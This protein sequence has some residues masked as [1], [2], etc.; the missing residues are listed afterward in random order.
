L[1]FLLSC[2]ANAPSPL[3]SQW[4][5]K[6]IKKG[7]VTRIENSR[8]SAITYSDRAKLNLLTN[9]FSA[10]EWIKNKSSSKQLPKGVY[11]YR[12]WLGGLDHVDKSLQMYMPQHKNLKW[13]QPLFLGLLEIALHNT[14]TIARYFRPDLPLKDVH[15]EMVKYLAGNHTLREDDK[16]PQSL[17]RYDNVGHYV[18]K[19][20][21]SKCVNCLSE[22]K[23]SNTPYICIK[24]GVHLHP[25]KCFINYH[26][27]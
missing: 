27:H 9:L 3:F 24:C 10:S 16:K 14:W 25:A 19:S 12:Q 17:K 26:T 15:T 23:Q 21:K 13:H 5:H 18:D 4:L 7:E 2:K 11:Y 1:G 22:G 6:T 20:T 8:I